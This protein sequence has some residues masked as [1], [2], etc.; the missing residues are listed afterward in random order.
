MLLDRSCHSLS[1]GPS[2][3]DWWRITT[4]SLPPRPFLETP[5]MGY[6]LISQNELSGVLRENRGPVRTETS[7][8]FPLPSLHVW[9]RVTYEKPRMPCSA[10]CLTTNTTG[11]ALKI[12]VLNPI[13]GVNKRWIWQNK[14][15]VSVI[16]HSK[17]KGKTEI[18]F[19]W[20]KSYFKIIKIICI[21]I[22][23]IIKHTSYSQLHYIIVKKL[24]HFL[25]TTQLTGK[26]TLKL[27]KW[28][29]IH[30]NSHK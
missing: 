7:S 2:S 5:F 23:M 16:F 29:E 30:I 3:A 27:F 8:G 17:S 22:F 9:C 20:R 11:W 28:F 10:I 26:C 6:S 15:N 14:T 4:S 18:T 24:I 21:N 1:S 13:K 25:K 12:L 19:A